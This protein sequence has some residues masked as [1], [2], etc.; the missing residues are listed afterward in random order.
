MTG[1]ESYSDVLRLCGC[2]ILAAVCLL[3]VR[4]LDKNGISGA[5]SVCFGAVFALA[6]ILAAKPVLEVVRSYG[7]LYFDGEWT[8]LL[9]RAMAIGITVQ[10]TADTI[11]D[12]GEGLLA[13]RVETVGRAVLLCIGMPLYREILSMAGQLLGM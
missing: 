2:A 9:F 13:D 5:I 7:E 4:G 8:D 10:L 1:L 3:V 11:R 12:A 6:A